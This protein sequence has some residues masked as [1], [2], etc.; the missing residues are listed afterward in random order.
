MSEP[1]T[2]TVINPGIAEACDSVLNHF[3]VMIIYII[4]E[5]KGSRNQELW[6]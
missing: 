5:K 2:I 3:N 4:C 6:Q 1:V